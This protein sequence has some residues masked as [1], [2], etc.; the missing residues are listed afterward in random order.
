MYGFLFICLFTYFF[1]KVSRLL[2]IKPNPTMVPIALTWSLLDIWVKCLRFKIT[3]QNQFRNVYGKLEI[4]YAVCGPNLSPCERCFS[5]LSCREHYN[6]SC[7]LNCQDVW[8]RILGLQSGRRL[9]VILTPS[10]KWK[11]LVFI[12]SWPP[13]SPVT[14][15]L[16]WPTFSQKGK[17]W[18]GANG[19][20]ARPGLLTSGVKSWKLCW[21]E[22]MCAAPPSAM[23][24]TPAC[25]G[26][27][28]LQLERSGPI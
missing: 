22:G 11:H 10:Y 19:L 20:V 21:K 2:I 26:V 6:S 18:G 8:S 1:F 24:S 14:I 12:L 25:R 7:F 4:S 23:D 3:H 5:V 17:V 9:L 15:F 16:T 13:S 27:C 28:L